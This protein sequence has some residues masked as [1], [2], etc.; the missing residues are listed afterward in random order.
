M[1]YKIRDYL[2]IIYRP[3]HA[4]LV[5]HVLSQFNVQRALEEDM[6]WDL[7]SLLAATLSESEALVL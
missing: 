5:K 2:V 7:G 4:N 6:P 3:P 1:P